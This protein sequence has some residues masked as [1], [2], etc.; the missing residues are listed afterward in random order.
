M[1]RLRM[2]TETHGNLLDADVDAVVNTVN[3]V[4]VMGK[5]I[6]LQF[7]RAYPDMFREYARAAK[8]GELHLG[9]MHVWPTGLLTGPRYVI[10]FPTKE[11]WRSSSRIDDIDRGLQDLTRVIKEL[12]IVS[13]AVPPLGCGNGGLDWS[14][15]E[16][17][18]RAALGGLECVD[19]ALFPPVGAPP[20]TTMVTAG[21]KPGM[22]RGRAALIDVMTRYAQ[23]AFENPALV[24]VQKLMYFLQLT[25]EP[26][27]LNYVQ[28]RY[29]P[30]A[31]NL[32][33]VLR[34]VEGHYLTGYGDGSSPVLE[35]E[36]LE[37]LP[38][39]VEAASMTLREHPE[40][41]RRIDRV[42][43]VV[44][45]FESMYGLELLA[46]VH[47]IGAHDPVAA[48]SPERM[49]RDVQ[50]WSPRKGRMFSDEHIRTAWETLR[51]RGW[52]P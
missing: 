22:T 11:H 12:Q 48:A 47:W 41:D 35:A 21:Q 20:A 16:P 24:E 33:H 14:V 15:V 34:V 18:I 3:T 23:H 4:G 7:R 13:V 26:L 37:V 1:E 9:A 36:P 52:L 42:L 32:R 30:Y 49:V 19:V 40:T 10:N 5:G 17:R 31:D 44:S 6:A 43:D 45:G 38:G 50:S 29:G 39:A 27:R 2:I 25:G 46:S 28:G 8:A 51:D